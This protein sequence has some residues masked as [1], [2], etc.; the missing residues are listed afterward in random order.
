MTAHDMAPD[1]SKR[2]HRH[3]GKQKHI[4]AFIFSIVL[5][6]IAFVTVASVGEVNPTF[7]VILLL[8]MAVLQVV[9]QMSYWMH[10]KD[11]GHVLPIVFMIG[12][13]IIAFTAIVM[14]VYWVWW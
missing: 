11:K 7:T 13:V 14:S 5:T 12:G 1:N 9:I 3:E 8:V 2:R 6:L 10:M 4:I